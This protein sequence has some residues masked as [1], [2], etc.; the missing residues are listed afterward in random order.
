[1]TLLST[2]QPATTSPLTDKCPW[3]GGVISR[4]KFLEIEARIR[5]QERKRLQETEARLNEKF[6]QDLK[7]HKQAAEKQAK[8]EADKRITNITTERDNAIKKAQQA[9]AREA[10]LRKQAQVEAEQKVKNALEQAER[11]RQKDLQN[12]RQI[13]DKDS[14]PGS[15]KAAGRVQPAAR[16]A[17]EE[18]K[19]VGAT[20]STQN[21]SRHRRRG[22]SRC[23]RRS[24]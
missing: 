13:L 23:F 6:Q 17:T 4:A 8:A 7:V 14:Q 2:T 11:Q 22:R 3:C 1:M 21:C 19:G 20:A 5:E 24:P 9:E 18:T 12:Q 16:S 10:A 15:P